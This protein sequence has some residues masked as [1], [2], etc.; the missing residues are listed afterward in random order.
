MASESFKGYGWIKVP[1]YVMDESQPWEVRYQQLQ[2][3]H[4]AETPFLIEKVREL[5]KAL[6][7]QAAE[8]AS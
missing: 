7:A 8:R 2:Q 3:H 4:I 5:A 1:K 6:D